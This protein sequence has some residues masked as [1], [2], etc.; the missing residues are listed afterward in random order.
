MVALGAL[1]WRIVLIIV[2]DGKY[3][4]DSILSRSWQGVMRGGRAVNSGDTD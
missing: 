2:T 1:L 3:H 4:G